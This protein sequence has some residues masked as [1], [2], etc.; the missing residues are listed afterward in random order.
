MPTCVPVRVVKVAQGTAVFE[1][2]SDKEQV[3]FVADA[4]QQVRGYGC[5]VVEYTDDGGSTEK[6]TYGPLDLKVRQIHALLW[7]LS[8]TVC[9]QFA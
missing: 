6:L 1:T 4:L 8:S 2:V 5:G 3:G 9:C 7:G